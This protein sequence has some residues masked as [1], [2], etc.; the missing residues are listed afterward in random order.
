VPIVLP[1]EGLRCG[2]SIAGPPY[3]AASSVPACGSL[4]ALARKSPVLLRSIKDDEFR[5]HP[6]NFHGPT[7][8]R[9]GE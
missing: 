4:L 3:V 5:Y 2:K 1:A 8:G 7:R 9:S 6:R